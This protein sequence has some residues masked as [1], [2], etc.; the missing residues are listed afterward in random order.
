MLDDDIYDKYLFSTE[1]NNRVVVTS[2]MT[3]SPAEQMGVLKDDIIM[4]YANQKILNWHDLRRLT[5]EGESGE[6]VNLL[7]L[8]NEQLINILVPRGPL[9]VKLTSTALNPETEYNY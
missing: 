2:V 1:Q 9:G 8:R 6:Y 7:V 5:S 3:G 4:S